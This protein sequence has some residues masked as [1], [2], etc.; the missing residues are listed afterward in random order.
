MKVRV[1]LGNGVWVGF[2]SLM[3]DN[4]YFPRGWN[5]GV[6]ECSGSPAVLLLPDHREKVV[7]F[8]R[9]R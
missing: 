9:G 2:L 6:L 3:A 7:V 8:S 4:E 5:L 1:I